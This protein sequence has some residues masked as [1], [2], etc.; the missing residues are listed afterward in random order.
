MPEPKLVEE[1]ASAAGSA[2]GWG[3]GFGAAF[4]IFRWFVRW[5]TERLDKRQA[6]LDAQEQRADDEWRKIRQEL[7]DELDDARAWRARLETQNNTWRAVFHHVATALIKV[8]PRNPALIEAE[9]VLAQAFPL[10][11]S[12]LAERAEAALDRGS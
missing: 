12:L 8:D 1:V 4:F 11:L 3:G 7:R 5:W 9:Q 2:V 6:N 10:D